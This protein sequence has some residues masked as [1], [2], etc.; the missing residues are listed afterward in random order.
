MASAILF[1]FSLA[2]AAI[3]RGTKSSK[4]RAFRP[5]LFPE[6]CEAAWLPGDDMF[7]SLLISIGSFCCAIL[8]LNVPVRHRKQYFRLGPKIFLFVSLFFWST[9]K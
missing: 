9:S 7:L 5:G 2:W 6:D 1:G 8:T 3:I 4:E